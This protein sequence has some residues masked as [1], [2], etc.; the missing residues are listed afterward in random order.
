[1]LW[2]VRHMFGFKSTKTRY[3][4]QTR[5][6]ICFLFCFLG[7]WDLNKRQ[8]VHSNCLLFTWAYLAHSTGFQSWIDV[9]Y[10]PW[11]GLHE[12][13]EWQGWSLEPCSVK[14]HNHAWKVNTFCI[15]NGRA[16]L[17]ALSLRWSVF[18]LLLSRYRPLHS[19]EQTRQGERARA[20]TPPKKK[21]A[22]FLWR[23]PLW[24][25]LVWFADNSRVG[26]HVVHVCS[27]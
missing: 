2:C 8:S 5:F 22:V 10:L 15:Q 9:K 6:Q 12:L 17:V 4:N 19:P 24:V 16:H 21:K 27:I 7:E 23:A 14:V 11:C 20:A 25:L 1:M 26:E 18:L 13:W 3:K